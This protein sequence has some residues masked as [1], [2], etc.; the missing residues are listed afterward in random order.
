MITRRKFLIS[1]AATSGALALAGC[2]SLSTSGSSSD[3][4]VYGVSGPFTGDNAEFGA[5][6]Y[7]AVKI[8]AWATEKDGADRV[9]IQQALVNGTN[10]PSVVSGPFKFGSDRRVAGIKQVVITVQNGQFALL[11]S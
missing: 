7:D 1:A 11:N 6:A 8:L 2:G 9:A 5:R 4:I 10:I 3:P